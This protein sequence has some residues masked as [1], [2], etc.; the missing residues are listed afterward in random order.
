MKLYTTQLQLGFVGDK[1]ENRDGAGHD[2]SDRQRFTQTEINGTSTTYLERVQTPL[3][4]SVMAFQNCQDV[5]GD[6]DASALQEASL[7]RV[8]YSSS[9]GRKDSVDKYK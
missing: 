3:H 8:S 1:R 7:N 5:Q 2:L 6:S 4:H 9:R